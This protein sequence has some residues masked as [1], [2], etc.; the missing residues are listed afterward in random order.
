MKENLLEI[1]W[2]CMP[3]KVLDR[4]LFERSQEVAMCKILE[5]QDMQIFIFQKIIEKYIIV[6]KVTMY[7]LI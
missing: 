1:S 2:C 6:R 3:G 5:I 4:I 7:S